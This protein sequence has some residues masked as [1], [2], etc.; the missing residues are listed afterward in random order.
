M[1]P[2]PPEMMRAPDTTPR[3]WRTIRRTSTTATASTIRLV[4]A[5]KIQRIPE[6]LDQAAP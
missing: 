1:L 3:G 6:K 2:T 4:T 5:T